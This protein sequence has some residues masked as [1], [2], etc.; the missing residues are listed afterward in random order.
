MIMDKKKILSIVLKVIMYALGLLT[1]VSAS[2]F[3]IF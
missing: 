2:A 1:G 3:D